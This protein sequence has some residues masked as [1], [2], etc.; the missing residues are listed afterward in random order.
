MNQ[1]FEGVF[2]RLR[3]GDRLVFMLHMPRKASLARDLAKLRKSLRDR[4]GVAV[5]VLGGWQQ[6]SQAGKTTKRGAERT[7][8]VSMAAKLSSDLASPASELTIGAM[9][10]ARAMAV[11]K[12]L[13]QS[14]QP[15][16]GVSMDSP[17]ELTKVMKALLRA[18]E[19][20]A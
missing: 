14:K 18:S 2:G 20:I 17:V 12:V 15:A 5:S 19:R 13:L 1:A 6:L 3:A 8:V 9:A 7:V 16:Y 10:Q 11:V 4:M